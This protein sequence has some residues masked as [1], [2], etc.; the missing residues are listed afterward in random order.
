MFCMYR[1]YLST[2]QDLYR[3]NNYLNTANILYVY[4]VFIPEISC[5]LCLAFLSLNVTVN[6]PE[7]WEKDISI[8]EPVGLKRLLRSMLKVKIFFYSLDWYFQALFTRA[9]VTELGKTVLS[10]HGLLQILENCQCWTLIPEE[11][12]IKVEITI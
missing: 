3:L 8:S 6:F 12:L 11:V 7:C 10:Q 1:S 2:G 9:G 4:G 5:L